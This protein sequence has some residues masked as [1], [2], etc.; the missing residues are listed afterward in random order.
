M[1]LVGRAR[2]LRR[3]HDLLSVLPQRGG[4]LILRGEPGIGKSALLHSAAASARARGMRVLRATGVQSEARLPF[5]GLHQLLFGVLDRLETL[6]PPQRHA[7]LAAFGMTER[8]T[9]DLFLLALASLNVLSE[10]AT[11]A[12][13]VIVV[14]DAHWLDRS[15]LDVLGFVAR[16]LESEPILVLGAIR[17]G[18]DGGGLPELRLE[19]LDDASSAELL[20]AV[21]PDLAPD[22][23][24][25]LLAEAAGNPLALVELPVASA[26]LEPGTL[27]PAWLPLTARLE[28][29]FAAQ[30]GELPA[31]TRRLLLIA[32]L[33]DGGS[34]SETLTADE[35]AIEA[36][37]PAIAARLAAVEGDELRFRHPL[38]RS[39]I[40]Q[41]ASVQERL[42][43]HAALAAVVEL[44]RRV[45]HR[46]AAVVGPDETTATELEWRRPL[47]ARKDPR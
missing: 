36:L 24:A 37:E 32:A 31:A 30:V 44:D 40:R 19:G 11:E 33:N 41:A 38:V 9:P 25:R 13:V 7:V 3:L 5:A 34:L 15:T 22:V 2:E 17:D 16:R 45:W 39:A 46:A 14:E 1:S 18:F 4:G 10:V 12:P 6:A 20:D 21:A 23:R 42:A 27:L 29:A 28:H 35:N 26:Q 47:K 8:E 43:A